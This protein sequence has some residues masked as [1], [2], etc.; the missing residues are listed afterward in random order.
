MRISTMLNIPPK[1]FGRYGRGLTYEIRK[2][3]IGDFVEF[4]HKRANS[5]YNCAQQI[6]MKVVTRRFGDVTRVYRIK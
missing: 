3:N 1:G 4:S 5:C 2:L 6:G